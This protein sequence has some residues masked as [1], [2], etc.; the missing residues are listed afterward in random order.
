MHAEF[1]PITQ[2]EAGG[3]GDG[4]GPSPPPHGSPLPP[5]F[6]VAADDSGD[7]DSP[8]FAPVSILSKTS[9]IPH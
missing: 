1:I 9:V 2:H 5:A 3:G 8:M 6:F 7:M 4:G